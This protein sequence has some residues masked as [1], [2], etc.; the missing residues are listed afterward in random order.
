MLSGSLIAA[1]PFELAPILNMLSGEYL[2]PE[3]EEDFNE[4]FVDFKEMK[5][6]NKFH[7]QD[8]AFGLISRMKPEYL[9][10]VDKSMYPEVLPEV[11]ADI[12]MDVNQYNN[13]LRVREKEIKEEKA[14]KID[15]GKRS[16]NKQK[17][18]AA[19]SVMGSFRV[20]SRQY[21]NFAPTAPIEKYYK[22]GDY[23]QETLIKE[24]KKMDKK[25]SS[26]AK[27]EY[28]LGR[29]YPSHLKRKGVVY[30]QFVGVCGAASIA[31]F[32]RLRGWREL[33]ADLK[34]GDYHKDATEEDRK[35]GAIFAQING[36]LSEEEQSNLVNYYCKK[37][38]DD[39]HLLTIIL[40][41]IEQCMGLDLTSVGYIVMFEPYWV[42]FLKDQLEHRGNRYRSHLTL[43]ENQRNMI[44]YIFC[45]DYPKTVKPEDFEEEAMRKTTDQHVY[46]KMMRNKQL[47]GSFK[48]ALEEI[49]IECELVNKFN[50]DSKHTCRTCVP[51]N[52]SLYTSDPSNAKKAFDLDLS[53]PTPC[54][55]GEKEDISVEEIVITD[56]QGDKTTYYYA[57][58][59][60]LYGYV[61]YYEVSKDNFEEVPPSSPVYKEI[62]RAIKEKKK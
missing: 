12:P 4:A 47:I 62:I 61:I 15:I 30:S 8:R 44:M 60:N 49:S 3:I 51:N 40:I 5:I 36:S 59:D 29:V 13:Y 1:S 26:S 22:Q 54:E 43:P 53:V 52:R 45:S 25:E 31:H 16:H 57:P 23:D 10:T 33:G 24:V 32:L 6:K 39:G 34:L 37:E 42:Y 28:L 46:E 17:F 50:P 9:G 27:A 48:E 35:A 18:K 14:K 19:E 20:R 56:S 55:S 11:K 58:S 21:C 2:Y 38:N 41:G 7:F